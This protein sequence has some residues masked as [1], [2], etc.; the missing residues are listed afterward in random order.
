MIKRRISEGGGDMDVIAACSPTPATSSPDRQ[1]ASVIPEEL[2]GRRHAG[3][4]EVVVSGQYDRV[5]IWDRDRFERLH[6]GSP[7]LDA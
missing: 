3:N 6:A 4:R 5:E 1:G 2:R 7:Q